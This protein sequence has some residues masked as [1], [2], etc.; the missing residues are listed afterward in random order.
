M[1]RRLFLACMLS[2]PALSRAAAP[3]SPDRDGYGRQKDHRFASVVVLYDADVWVP[4]FLKISQLQV[5]FFSHCFEQ[6][7][8]PGIAFDPRPC[9]GSA[10]RLHCLDACL[11]AL[12]A[13]NKGLENVNAMED[14]SLICSVSNHDGVLDG[15][16]DREFDLGFSEV[17]R[18]GRTPRSRG[19]SVHAICRTST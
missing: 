17:S 5:K 7:A 15:G 3:F 2:S 10:D 18:Y 11:T 9:F 16:I 4:A 14:G 12:S 1:K 19:S 13:I 8:C 6:V